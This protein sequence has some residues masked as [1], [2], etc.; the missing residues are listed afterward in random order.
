[1]EERGVACLEAGQGL[2]SCYGDDRVLLRKVLAHF[3]EDGRN[4]LGLDCQENDVCSFHN[5]HQDRFFPVLYQ[6]TA[7]LKS[8]NVHAFSL[9][10]RNS[11][12]WFCVCLRL[13]PRH[14]L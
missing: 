3:L 7:F 8:K 11:D 10:M 9:S 4:K 1:M 5:L 12:V 13:A 14:C 2:S 6:I